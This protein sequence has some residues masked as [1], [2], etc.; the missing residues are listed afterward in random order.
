ML[1]Y[2]ASSSNGDRDNLR[3]IRDL[4]MPKV[5]AMFYIPCFAFSGDE[6]KCIDPIKVMHINQVALMVSHAMVV[7]YE[8]VESIGIWRELEIAKLREIPA[9]VYLHCVKRSGV[10]LSDVPVFARLSEVGD[11]LNEL[12]EGFKNSKESEAGMVS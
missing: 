8:G 5:E 12:Q 3:A 7:V 4:L 11:W 6:E 2:F 1:I 9:C 10:S